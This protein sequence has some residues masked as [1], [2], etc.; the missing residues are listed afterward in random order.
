MTVGEFKI[1]ESII[2]IAF[3]MLIKFI[4]TVAIRKA[5][6]IFS[7]QES[8]IKIIKKIFNIT[9]FLYIISIM[10]II[11]GVNQSKFFLFLSSVLTILGV[12]YF[13]QWSTLSNA[14]STL[15]LFF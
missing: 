11:F 14:T 8:R 15:I 4:S 13:A 5:T 2:V 12:A 10:L 6:Q 3:F 9:V 1:L 7:Y